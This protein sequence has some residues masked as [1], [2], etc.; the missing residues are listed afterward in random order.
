MAQT[1][2][3]HTHTRIQRVCLCAAL[4]VGVCTYN[5]QFLFCSCIRD[6]VCVLFATCT[7][8]WRL[9]R[10]HTDAREF[11]Q[12][13]HCVALCMA[14]RTRSSVIIIQQIH[15]VH[16][17]AI[18]VHIRMRVISYI[19]FARNLQRHARRLVLTMMM[20]MRSCWCLMLYLNLTTCVSMVR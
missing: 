14:L 2:T 7:R 1:A 18:H 11:V 5:V 12:P 13:A 15:S 3:L 8:T 4:S 10:L 9:Q 16:M 19:S 20:M 6:G 17:C